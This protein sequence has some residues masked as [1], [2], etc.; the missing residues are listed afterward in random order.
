MGLAAGLL[1][2]AAG[3][4]AGEA[5]KAPASAR[6]LANPVEREAG[7]RLGQ[8]LYE[9][10]CVICHGPSGRGDGPVAA[11]LTPRPGRLGDRAVQ[12]QSDG[13]LFWKLTTGRGG[14]PGWRGLPE[15]ER[16]ALVHH[17]RALA[18]K[19]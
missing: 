6:G 19:Q 16:W 1:L 9:E 11:G 10:N 2:A 3:A 4:M 14:M 5:W 18:G 17:L 15:R 7:R 8:A 12:S 13:E